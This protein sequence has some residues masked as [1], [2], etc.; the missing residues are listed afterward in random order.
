MKRKLLA[1]GILLCTGLLSSCTNVAVSQMKTTDSVFTKEL[2]DTQ[3]TTLA[4]K[5]ITKN[6]TINDPV[7]NI[8]VTVRWDPTKANA[9][10]KFIRWEWYTG[11]ELISKVN[12]KF[13][14]YTTPFILLGNIPTRSLGLGKH[15]VKLFIEDIQFADEAFEVTN[16]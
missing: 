11:A 13:N 3:R 2:A 14:F 10:I 15:H 8:L 5:G 7:V 9:G 16:E 1:G 4:P 12:A 6:F